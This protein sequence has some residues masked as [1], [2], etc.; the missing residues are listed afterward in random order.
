[1]L[2]TGKVTQY[3]NNEKQTC[4]IVVL[5]AKLLSILSYSLY[6]D[7]YTIYQAYSAFSLCDTVHISFEQVIYIWRSIDSLNNFVHWL[8]EHGSFD[9]H[10]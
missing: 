9:G 6:K 4:L 3:L 7:S 1:M 10:V 5:A 2:P 8:Y